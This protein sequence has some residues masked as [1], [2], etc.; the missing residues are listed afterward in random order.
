MTELLDR[1]RPPAG[2]RLL[3]AL[4]KEPDL[5]AMD[6][7]GLARFAA[8]ENRKRSSRFARVITGRPDRDAV[9]HWR[10]VATR[11]RTIRVRVYRPGRDRAT[12]LG[13]LP[14]VLHVHG[15]GFVG[16]AAQ[17]DWINSHLA[18]HLPAVVISV[19]HRL[20]VPGVSLLDA[21]D[22]G[23]DVLTEVTRDPGT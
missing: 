13:L 15:G 7:Q 16:T 5:A 18:T 6:A 8:K 12:G 2:V 14:L 4:G 3:H 11:D 17:S 10:E 1:D 22:D 21:V 9:I 20:L 23:W 19:E